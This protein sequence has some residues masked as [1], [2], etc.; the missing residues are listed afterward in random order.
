MARPANKSS[1]GKGH[2]QRN[3][4]FRCAVADLTIFAVLSLLF[5]PLVGAVAGSDGW[6]TV[7]I[8]S[9]NGPQTVVLD[10]KGDPVPDKAPT[11][12]HVCP[13]CS[14]HAGY[15]LPP[16]VSPGVALPTIA[17]ASSPLWAVAV[18]VPE[19]LFLIGHSPRD[20]PLA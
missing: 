1:R 2:G 20:P 16:P 14:A 3:G 11:H 4:W 8:C 12:Q 6:T 9:I 15:T 17:T 18:I 19:P 7:E 10:E 5:M 13:F